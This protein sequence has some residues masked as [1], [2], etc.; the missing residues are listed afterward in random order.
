MPSSESI[1]QTHLLRPRLFISLFSSSAIMSLFGTSPTENER[2]ANLPSTPKRSGGGGGGAGGLFND[3]PSSGKGSSANGSSGL[4]ADDGGHGQGGGGDDSS[5]W[6]MPTPRKRQSR[7]EMIRSLLPAGDVPE[8]YIDAFDTVVKRRGGGSGGGRLASND[9]VAAVFAAARLG[10]EAQ[11]RVVSLLSDGS[12][13]DGLAL[14]RSEFNVL[15]ALVGLA[16]EGEVV[17]LDGVDERRRSE[18]C[19][20]LRPLNHRIPYSFTSSIHYSLLLIIVIM[21]PS[22]P[23]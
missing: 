7:A 6:D 11:A 20:F 17:S 15:L 16:Q 18:S 22:A 3:E 1:R 14:G 23:Y 5:P 21:S 12:S 13:G 10:S 2:N 8:S 19:L 4:F 9:D